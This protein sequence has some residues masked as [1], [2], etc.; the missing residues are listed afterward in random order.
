MNCTAH[1]TKQ[2]C[3]S[4]L[5]LQNQPKLW[6][7]AQLLLVYPTYKNH[8]F[9]EEF[10]IEI[11]ILCTYLSHRHTPRNSKFTIPL[12]MLGVFFLLSSPYY[13]CLSCVCIQSANQRQLI[14][15]LAHILA[16]TETHI[17]SNSTLR[18]KGKG[19][20]AAY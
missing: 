15:F 13:S 1:I 19:K 12:Y 7:L 16:H 9:L 20:R 3:K 6:L 5:L 18:T 14:H 17:I 8:F 11:C 4:P 10:F 2:C